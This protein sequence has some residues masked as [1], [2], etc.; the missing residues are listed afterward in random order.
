[1]I[2][3]I[4]AI[5]SQKETLVARAIYTEADVLLDMAGK[6]HPQDYSIRWIVFAK[7]RLRFSFF[8]NGTVL[9]HESNESLMR[10]DDYLNNLIELHKGAI[11]C[12]QLG[13][14]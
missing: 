10:Y 5:V 12:H 14:L 4:R 2:D 11:L 7:G 9:F 1:M 13:I 6:I 8:N 3:H